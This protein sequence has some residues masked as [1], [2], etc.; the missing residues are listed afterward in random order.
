VCFPTVH[1]QKLHFIAILIVK[2]AQLTS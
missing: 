2:L 1:K